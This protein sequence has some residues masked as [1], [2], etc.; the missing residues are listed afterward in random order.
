MTTFLTLK[1]PSKFG[2]LGIFLEVEKIQGLSWPIPHAHT[3]NVLEMLAFNVTFIQ[4]LNG[5]WGLERFRDL[6]WY[7]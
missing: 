4:V 2:C 5:Y 6:Y 1:L 7:C 3:C